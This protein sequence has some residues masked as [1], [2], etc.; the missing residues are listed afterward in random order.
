V[1]VEVPVI[2]VR[3]FGKSYVLSAGD[4]ADADDQRT[5][6]ADAARDYGLR[7]RFPAGAELAAWGVTAGE[8]PAP[9]AA[10]SPDEVVVTGTLE[11]RPALPGWVG[12]WK[13]RWRGA[14]YAWGIRGVNYDQA[15]RD[16]IRGVVRAASGHGA[17]D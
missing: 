4:P 14:G 3:G 16:L 9:R 10:Q 8:V 2:A 15:F 13:M 11:F 12:S 7:V 5:A 6:F 1:L 17:P